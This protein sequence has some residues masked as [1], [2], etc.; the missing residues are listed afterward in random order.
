MWQKNA[1]RRPDQDV[2][3]Y[4][5]QMFNANVQSSVLSMLHLFRGKVH[6]RQGRVKPCPQRELSLLLPSNSSTA[7]ASTFPSDKTNK[8]CCSNWDSPSIKCRL[9]CDSNSK[10]CGCSEGDL[11]SVSGLGRSPVGRH[12]NPTSVFLPGESPWT[13]EPG[14]L[15]S[16]GS[17]RVGHN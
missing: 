9:L 10:E 13:E 4:I 6:S 12:G 5:M 15:Q 2:W 17:Q 11:G 14:G 7:Q 16:M 1:K 8:Q 3:E